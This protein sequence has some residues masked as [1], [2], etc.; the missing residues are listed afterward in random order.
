MEPYICLFLIFLSGLLLEL[1]VPKNRKLA[2]LVIDAT[3]IMFFC[4][5][6]GILWLMISQLWK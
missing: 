1:P 6:Y 3:P 5:G 2:N 4:G